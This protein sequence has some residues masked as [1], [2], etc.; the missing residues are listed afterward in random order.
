MAALQSNT[1]S[2]TDTTTQPGVRKPSVLP[3]PKG[4]RQQAIAQQTS[5][6]VTSPP[7]QQSGSF[8]SKKLDIPSKVNEN[9]E[10]EEYYSCILPDDVLVE[11]IADRLQVSETCVCLRDSN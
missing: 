2:K 6:A 3:G 4:A 11:L 1:E 5:A 8:T 10:E 7:A 9:G